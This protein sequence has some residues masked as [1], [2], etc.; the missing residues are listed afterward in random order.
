MII[1]GRAK[2]KLILPNDW[3]HVVK[4]KIS[5]SDT[6]EERERVEHENWLKKERKERRRRQ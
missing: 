3:S 5:L 4:G 2:T 1:G 6:G